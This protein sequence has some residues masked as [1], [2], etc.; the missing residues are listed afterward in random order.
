MRDELQD[1]GR[2]PTTPFTHEQ[3]QFLLQL[4]REAIIHYLQDGRLPHHESSHPDLTQQAGVFVT[5]RQQAE[6]KLLL[7]GCIG[8][9]EAEEPLYKTLS[10][11]AVKAATSDPRFPPVSLD[12]MTHI[13]I[14]ISVLSP[15]RSLTDVTLLE[16]GTHGLVIV[17]GNRRG[18]LLPQVPI[19]QQWDRRQFLEGICRKAGLP[20]DYWQHPKAHLYVFTSFV[21]E[22]ER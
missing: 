9:I 16:I 13:H 19:A 11:M 7:R 20:Q 8:R 4:A 1:N 17:S 10:D 12:E 14:E 3:Q 22:D 2:I 6:D 5:L 15:L 18:L 21:F